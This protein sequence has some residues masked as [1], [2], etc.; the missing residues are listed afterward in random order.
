[1][2]GF[3]E[4]ND[5]NAGFGSL[6]ENLN[7][8]MIESCLDGNLKACFHAGYCSFEDEGNWYWAFVIDGFG[9]LLASYSSC[10]L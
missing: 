5:C 3:S 9:C 7:A 2:E 10:W 1:M 4:Q 6:G 8:D